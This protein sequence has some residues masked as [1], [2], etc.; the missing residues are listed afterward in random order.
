MKIALY[1]LQAGT[2]ADA[3]TLLES[4]PGASVSVATGD[5]RALE[6]LAA[7]NPDVLLCEADPGSPTVAAL[8]RV[9]AS[10]PALTPM[11]LSRA[12][13][14]ELLI[15]AMR[16]GVREV[17]PLPLD[18]VTV[19]AALER[20]R[21]QTQTVP[22]RHGKVLAFI[23]CKGGSG[24]TFLATNL[25]WTLSQAP[26]NA[27]VLLVDLHL[28]FGDAALFLTSESPPSNLAQ[29]VHNTDRLD[30]ALLSSSLLWLTPRLGVLASADDLGA[31]LE[32]Q[33]GQVEALLALARKEF[34]FVVLDL[35]RTLDPVTVKAL[36]AADRIYP[37]LQATLPFVR[38]SRRLLDAFQSLGYPNER[39]SLI[40]N[41]A[42]K[43]GDIRQQDI[44]RTLG[45]G[46]AY[47]VP[48][49]YPL[50]A[51]S[52]NQ[53]LPLAKLS[54]SSPVVQALGQIATDL[55]PQA[56]KPASWWQRLRLGGR[57]ETVAAKA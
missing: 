33:P 49:N 54:P 9:S 40:V 3:R 5:A 6:Q 48:N 37:V 34:D 39:V 26:D 45:R 28:Q 50:V 32:I 55:K 20:L 11:L 35:G 14:P 24:A 57:N 38:D 56:D 18:R 16:A 46:I 43:H 29:L 13:T 42:S 4:L 44:E 19:A 25:A 12:P 31:G 36:D 1:C 30:A 41:R 52:V 15:E 27:R 22:G 17:L 2:A 47:S 53:G 8:A 51:S 10:R 23:P 7:G 21:V